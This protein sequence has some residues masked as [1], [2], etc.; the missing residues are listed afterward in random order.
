VA[1]WEKGGAGRNFG[2]R[3]LAAAVMALGALLAP[4]AG[5]DSDGGPGPVDAGVDRPMADAPIDAPPDA[6]TPD[7]AVDAPDGA[8]DGAPP[9][10]SEPDGPVDTRVFPDAMAELAL[11]PA[12]YDFTSVAVDTTASHTFEVENLGDVGSGTPSVTV[13]GAT[14]HFRVISNQCE[15]ALDPGTTCTIEVEFAPTAAGEQGA[16]LEVEASPG[17]RVSSQLTGTGTE[18]DAGTDAAIDAGL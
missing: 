14:D 9:D 4:G 16:L 6:G 2:R 10:A 8:R 18:A 1:A 13:S 17:G 3:G 15:T 5:C 12:A 7:G 11:E